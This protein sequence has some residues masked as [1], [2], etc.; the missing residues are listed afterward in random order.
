MCSASWRAPSLE[1]NLTRSVRLA[2]SNASHVKARASARSRVGSSPPSRSSAERPLRRRRHDADGDALP[3]LHARL[4]LLDRACELLER[5]AALADLVRTCHRLDRREQRVARQ[6]GR[7]ER[8][9]DA[10]GDFGRVAARLDEGEGLGVGGGGGVERGRVSGRRRWRERRARVSGLRTA[11]LRT[12]VVRTAVL[13]FIARSTVHTAA[14]RGRFT[15]PYR[16]PLLP[17]RHEN[18]TKSIVFRAV[19]ECCQMTIDFSA[20]IFLRRLPN[21]PT[22]PAAPFASF[23]AGVVTPAPPT[24]P[25]VAKTSFAP[26]RPAVAARRRSPRGRRRACAAAGP[27]WRRG[28]EARLQESWVAPWMQGRRL[29]RRLAERHVGARR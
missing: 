25:G 2:P 5:R 8:V 28:G 4:L 17:I 22:A 13:N 7:G 14:R 19:I 15:V 11:V 23:D 20:P 18:F 26:R 21:L 9:H 1:S 27:P 29:A 16:Y 24:A 3:A 12:A 6:P 10:G